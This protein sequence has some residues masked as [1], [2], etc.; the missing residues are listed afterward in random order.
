MRMRSLVVVAA[1]VSGAL[2]ATARAEVPGSETWDGRA[3]TGAHCGY[4]NEMA[5]GERALLMAPQIFAVTGTSA[6]GSE[7]TG[8]ANSAVE[9]SLRRTVGL[10]FS[11]NRLYRAR[12]VRRQADA[13]CARYR[14]QVQIF[15]ALSFGKETGMGEALGAELAVL[16]GSLGEVRE[17]VGRL[18]EQAEAR[19]ATQQELLVAELKLE[20]FQSQISR[21]EDELEHLP[22]PP[23]GDPIRLGQLL[24]SYRAADLGVAR[25]ETEL[26]EASA[27]DIDFRGGYDDISGQS[28]DLPVFAT[29][30]VTISLGALKQRKAHSRALEQRAHWRQMEFAGL[31]RQVS[32]LVRSLRAGHLHASSRL[33]Q[34]VSLRD[35]LTARLARIETVPGRHVLRHRE[36][37]WF[38]SVQL[39]AQT[40]HFEARVARVGDFLASADG[41]GATP[42]LARSL[43][44]SC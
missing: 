15:R 6:S 2:P 10:R 30:N 25:A 31:E 39:E 22:P 11:A 19:N 18:R 23:A 36:N 26:R 40:A 43:P 20:S 16:R 8:D 38:E 4:V 41:P 35:D 24:E 42:S 37:L 1:L 17:I 9:A 14:A 3:E 29:M 28:R 21:L 13:E 32:D 7:E 5:N 34:L 44:V 27:W 12:L 33:D